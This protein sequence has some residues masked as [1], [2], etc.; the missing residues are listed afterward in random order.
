MSQEKTF[1]F[2]TQNLQLE[3]NPQNQRSESSMP[4]TLWQLLVSDPIDSDKATATNTRYVT[5]LLHAVLYSG[6]IWHSPT[7]SDTP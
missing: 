1:F 4:L 3:T 7:S 5:V 2:A 6:F